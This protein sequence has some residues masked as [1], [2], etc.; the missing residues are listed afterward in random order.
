MVQM[1]LP[2][3]MTTQ[4]IQAAL[5]FLASQ[6][7]NARQH[8]VSG[9]LPANMI[10]GV[11]PDYVYEFQPYPKALTPPDVEVTDA[12]Q[13]AALRTKWNDQLPWARN[14]PEG[15]E[16][17]RA[18]YSEREYPVC[19]TPPQIVVQDAS[20]EAAVRAGWQAE[21]G[22]GEAKLFPAWKFHPSKK[23]VLVNNQREEAALG[24]GWF[25]QPDEAQSAAAGRKPAVPASDELD[26]QTMIELAGQLGIQID[27]RMKTPALREKIRVH[28][29][30]AKETAEI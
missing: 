6:T 18:Y 13:E 19:M 5:A 3:G 7:S 30:R 4:A 12:K 28:Q 14:E 8:R 17:I 9:L 22:M 24:D 20:E 1:N 29:E 23:P 2:A 26:R 11:N 25:D 15:Q 27:A 21:Y 16:L 10:R